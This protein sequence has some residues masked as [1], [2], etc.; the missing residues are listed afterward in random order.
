MK[1]SI[2]TPTYNSE[3][4]IARN[5]TSVINQ[6]YKDFE[7]VI[8]DNKSEDG[9][10]RLIKK[11]YDENGLGDQ[12]KI[13]SEKD[14][15]ISNAFNKGIK[16]ATGEVIAILNSDDAYYNDKVFEQ[17]M[18]LFRDSEILF[19]HGDVYFDDPIYGSNVRKPLLCPITTAMPYNHPTMFLRK[20]IYEKFGLFDL[21]YKYAMDFEFIVRFEKSF[22]EFKVKG[23]YF[24]EHPIAKMYS[25]GASWENELQSIEETQKALKKYGFWNSSAK[26]NY[27]IRIF[28]TRLKKFLSV[29]NLDFVVKIWRNTKWKREKTV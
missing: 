29:L 7:Q 11:F 17:V 21:S 12:L 6:S 18:S 22:P 14:S 25:G 28:R 9:T 26:K 4:T 24:S 10:L 5:V 16:A 1:I 13:I 2:I 8:V 3:K 20:E 27:L 23:K 19:V 15:G